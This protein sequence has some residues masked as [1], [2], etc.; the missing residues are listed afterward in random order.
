MPPRLAIPGTH[1]GKRLT[2]TSARTG[3]NESPGL[4]A[5]VR[6]AL[7]AIAAGTGISREL[8]A[9]LSRGTFRFFTNTKGKEFF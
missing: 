1:F 9:F 3:E 2:R 7:R 4:T 8:W 5:D 6:A